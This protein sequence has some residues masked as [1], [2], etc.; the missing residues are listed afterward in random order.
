MSYIQS[1]LGMTEQI[2]FRDY[3][4]IN[5]LNDIGLVERSKQFRRILR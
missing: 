4:W 5:M 2:K 3:K 1:C